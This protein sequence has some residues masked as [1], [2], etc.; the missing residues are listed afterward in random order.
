MD[1]ATW[2][3]RGLDL[4]SWNIDPQFEDPTNHDFRLKLESPALQ[5]GFRQLDMR[6]CGITGAPRLLEVARRVER[7]VAH[8]PRR[9]EAPALSLED[10]FEETPVGATADL[11]FTS[12]ETEAATIR[13][14]AAQ[15]STG[16]HSLQFRSGPDLAHPYVYYAPNITSGTVML[17]YDIR[18][19]RGSVVRNEWRDAADPYRVGPS[20][21]IDGAGRLSAAGEELAVL[22]TGRWLHFEV[23]CGVG[24]RSEGRWTLTVAA[25]GQP[26]LANRTLSC[27][28]K[29]QEV[30]W[31]GFVSGGSEPTALYLDNISLR[32]D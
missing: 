24:S 23:V 14:S 15:A 27:D 25:S 18:V 2:K 13:V 30:R 16:K 28:P 11:A 32:T 26:L 20:L 22:P 7:N 4:H 9:A 5:H 17:R 31:L 29:F 21:V 8:V 12:G 3:S 19:G 1:W 10:G 6:G